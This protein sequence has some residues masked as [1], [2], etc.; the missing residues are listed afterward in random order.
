[1]R[2]FIFIIAFLVTSC[3]KPKH[4]WARVVA[5][6]SLKSE[7]VSIYYSN[8][9]NGEIEP[10]GCITNPKGGIGRKAQLFEN[11]KTQTGQNFLY[12]D[13]GDIFFKSTEVSGFLQKQWE[14]QAELLFQVYASLPLTAMTIGERDFS[15]GKEFL[16]SHAEKYKLPIVTSNIVDMATH[17]SLFQEYLIKTI[18]HQKFGVFALAHPSHFEKSYLEKLG[19]SILDPEKKAREM[20]KKLRDEKVDFI[21]LLSHVG[22]L[23]EV[24][25]VEKIQGIDIVI[26]GHSGDLIL[27]PKKIGE[28]LILQAGY[29]GWYVGKLD[30]EA[31]FR[32]ESQ[33]FQ[34]LWNKLGISSSTKTKRNFTHSMITLSATYDPGPQ[35]I[36]NLIHDFKNKLQNISLDKK[37]KPSEK[38]IAYETYISCAQCH[39][40]QVKI[41]KESNHA[42]AFI[43]VYSKN[44]H[45]NRECVACHT[46]GFQKAG[47][48]TDIK[49]A[50]YKGEKTLDQ[51]QLVDHM[52]LKGA[53]LDPKLEELIDK[54]LSYYQEELK[55]VLSDEER[56]RIKNQINALQK[57]KKNKSVKD[58]YIS[59]FENKEIYNYLKKLYTGAVDKEALDKNYW[60]VQCESCHG[61]RQGH[62]FEKSSPRKKVDVSLC[63]QCHNKE[64]SPR[65]NVKDF[66]RVHG[67]DKR[68][69]HG[70][71]C[72]VE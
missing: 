63:L 2:V 33:T 66:H 69:V 41:W 54:R 7:L 12:F 71:I 47:G 40:K 9:V 24:D 39:T 13:S 22:L 65:F 44:Q 70:F 37:D 25:T 49:R 1:M 28:T 35:E 3:S 4:E 6:E 53:G 8:N 16:I 42:S 5:S 38:I 62:P 34:S 57:F 72:S 50:S 64:H 15:L 27:Q 55:K 19:I 21:V 18:N 67:R 32:S 60:G 48:F 52:V 61:A 29:E 51:A 26:G 11:L 59:F 17:K 46:V 45:F 58:T 43:S 10:C 68:G 36:Q 20:I 14:L 30:V 31:Q 23:H 56:G